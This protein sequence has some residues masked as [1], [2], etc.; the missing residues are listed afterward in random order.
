MWEDQSE[1]N[2]PAT[3]ISL[4]IADLM[5]VKLK[6][7]ILMHTCALIT[8]FW[9]SGDILLALGRSLHVT[10]SLRFSI[11]AKCANLLVGLNI[12]GGTSLLCGHISSIMGCV[13]IFHY[14]VN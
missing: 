8:L 4:T 1:N 13:P 7:N 12:M 14:C 5:K 11:G 9:T 6:K 3:I 2:S 10:G